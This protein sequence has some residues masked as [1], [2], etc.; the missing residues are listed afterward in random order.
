MLNG[1]KFQKRINN[2]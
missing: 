1:P 2:V